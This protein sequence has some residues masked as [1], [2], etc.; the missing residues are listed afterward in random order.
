[1]PDQT[2]R[3]LF[4]RFQ[5]NALAGQ[6]GLD[7]EMLADD[8][9]V[10]QPFAPA[11]HRRIEGREKVAAMTRAGR[12]ALSIVFEEFRDVVIHETADPEVIIA[13][14]QMVATMPGS[15]ARATAA[16]AVVLRARDGRIAH[17]REYQD[18]AAIAEAMA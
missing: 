12:E 3:D 14:Y 7:E 2:P 15:G 17:W 1:M 6:A 11:G 9:V 5:R 4:A 16:F 10:E 18:R 13:E 8:V